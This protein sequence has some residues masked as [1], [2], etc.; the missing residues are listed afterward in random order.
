[1]VRAL[2][3]TSG[4]VAIQGRNLALW[5]NYRGADPD[6]NSNPTGDAV[7]DYGTVAEP[8]QWFFRVNLGY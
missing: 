8:H 2:R 5:S 1:M 6:V 7:V 4:S 3:A